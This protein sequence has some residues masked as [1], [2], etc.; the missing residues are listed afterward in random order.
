MFSTSP[1]FCGQSFS[2]VT[3][4]IIACFST[5][6]KAFSWSK[7]VIEIVVLNSLCIASSRFIVWIGGSFVDRPDTK[8]ASS[9]V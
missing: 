5:E 6:S 9:V 2:S 8:P 4:F 3:A 7:N 1:K